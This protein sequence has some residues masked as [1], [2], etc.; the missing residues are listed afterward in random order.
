M[1]SNPNSKFPRHIND[2]L[3]ENRRDV[4]KGRPT[5][6]KR[7]KSAKAFPPSALHKRN[8]IRKASQS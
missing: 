8:L 2:F 6:Y 3:A 4:G 5:S 1:K 7:R